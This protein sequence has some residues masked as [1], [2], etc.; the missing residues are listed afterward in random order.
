VE[1]GRL[2]IHLRADMWY[3]QRDRQTHRGH[4]S[5]SESAKLI[6]IVCEEC[7]ANLISLT[8]QGVLLLQ[9]C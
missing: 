9:L 5:D 1:V 4:I 2:R 8:E 7:A 6:F 3:G